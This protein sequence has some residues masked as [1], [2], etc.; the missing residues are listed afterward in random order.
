MQEFQPGLLRIVKGTG[1]PVVPIYLHGLW[2]SVFSH[3]GGRL[4]WKWPR[5][6]PY[7]VWIHFGKPIPEPQDVHEVQRAVEELGE[8]AVKHDAAQ[9]L[10]PVRQFI[11]NCK[12]GKSKPKIADS[13]GLELTGG[14]LLAGA[15]A[16]KR[17]LQ[18]HV[19]AA[20]EKTVGILLPPSVGG[21]L[22]NV[23]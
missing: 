4:F 23:V 7:P 20:D 3:A 2:G 9:T 12:R 13:S 21:A 6:W 5:K 15:I 1:A 16:M 8:Q 22:A 10:I 11:R 18:R 14:K 17:A 19:L